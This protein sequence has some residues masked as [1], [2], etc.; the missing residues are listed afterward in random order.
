MFSLRVRLGSYRKPLRL[1]DL[2]KDDWTY[3]WEGEAPAEPDHPHARQEP[4]PPV[5]PMMA[6]GMKQSLRFLYQAWGA[7]A[8][9]IPTMYRRFPRI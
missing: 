5:R 6:P 7:S 9:F 1:S 3:I 4:R 8:G 2:G